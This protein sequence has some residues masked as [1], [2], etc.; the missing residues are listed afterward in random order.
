MTLEEAHAV[1]ADAIA[2]Q[3]SHNE[4]AEMVGLSPITTGAWRT[5][6]E[7]FPNC[8]RAVKIGSRVFYDKRDVLVWMSRGVVDHATSYHTRRLVA[9]DTI[10]HGVNTIP[11]PTPVEPS[12]PD[13]NEDEGKAVA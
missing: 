13:P 5:S 11:W 4:A 10:A 1:I 12:P 2:N 8:P 7:L 6:P 9:A 3:I